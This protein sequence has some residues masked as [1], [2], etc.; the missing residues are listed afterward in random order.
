MPLTKAV[1]VAKAVP[2]DAALYHLIEVPVAVKLAMVAPEQ[3][4]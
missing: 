4:D 3:N 1:V 2:P